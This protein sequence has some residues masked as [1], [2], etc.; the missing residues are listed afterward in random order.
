MCVFRCNVCRGWRCNYI[1]FLF[2]SLYI[3]YF[4]TCNRP[5]NRSC[6]V[7]P[8]APQG[9]ASPTLEVSAS[10]NLT[11]LG[12]SPSDPNGFVTAYRY[13]VNGSLSE[14]SS[15]PGSVTLF[16]LLPYTIYDVILEICTAAGCTM[17]PSTIARTTSAGG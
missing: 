16:N 15:V 5:L 14:T 8:T 9:V 11:F 10:T 1:F 17:S 3:T 12:S 2:T 13:Y 6:H 7:F 4:F